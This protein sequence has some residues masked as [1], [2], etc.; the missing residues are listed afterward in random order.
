MSMVQGTAGLVLGAGVVVG[1]TL[2]TVYVRK[3]GGRAYLRVPVASGVAVLVGSVVGALIVG[4]FERRLGHPLGL[5]ALLITMPCLL[6]AGTLAG[7]WCTRGPRPDRLKRGTQLQTA[8]AG[9]KVPS[10]TDQLRFAGLPIAPADETK[11]FKIIGTTGTGKSTAIRELIGGALER[12]D[13]LVIADPDSG[14]LRRFHSVERGDR[15][16]NPLRPESVRW[17]LWREVRSRPDSD[18]LARSLIADGGTTERVWNQYARTFVAALLRQGF[19]MGLTEVGELH[20]LIAIAPVDELRTLLGGTAAQ[21]FLE[22]GNERMFGSVRAVASSALG[23]LE[24]V[25]SGAGEGLSIRDW[26][27]EGRGVLF[28]PYQATE[29]ASLRSLISTWMRLAIFEAMNVG[30][31]DQRLWFV[32][33]ELDALGAIDGLKDALARLRKFGGRCVLGFQSIAQVSGTYGDAEAHTIVEN[34]ANTL[35]LRCSASEHGGTAQFASRLIGD[36]EVVRTLVSR[37]KTGSIGRD[38]VSRSSQ[39]VVEAAVMPS[40]IEGLPDLAGYRKAAGDP[41][42]RCVKLVAE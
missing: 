10:R 30:E 24:Y 18:Q 17:D 33:D 1:S 35:I 6:I 8:G 42:W 2:A 4:A 29:I 7:L 15:I 13:R 9:R 12:G 36:R 5:V 37:T 28:L 14:Y 22:V 16:L 21:P 41:A 11:H 3:G 34:C 32:V 23:A 31:G 26:V 27:R 40:E 19:E 39:H 20:R 25:G 38:A